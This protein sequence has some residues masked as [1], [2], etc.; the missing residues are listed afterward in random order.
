MTLT[1]PPETPKSDPNTGNIESANDNRPASQGE[2]L[3]PA[4][5]LDSG[6]RPWKVVIGCFCLTVPTFGLLSGISLF[7]TY[8]HKYQ[9][10][11]YTD[12]EISWIISIFGFL[13]CFF[14]AP[15]GILFD[16]Y[17][18]RW[19]LLVGSMVYV[20]A[21]IGLAFSSTYAKFMGCLTVAGI[22]AA[23]PTTIAFSIV[24]QWFSAREGLAT[25]CVSLGAAV[26]GIFF[27]L[28]L[29]NLFDK[30]SWT[31]VALI[32]SVIIAGFMA[33]G[34]VLV[35]TN[36]SRRPG[37][38]ALE[39]W[40]FGQVTQLLQSPKFWLISYAV[41]AYEV[42]LFIQ[43]GSIPAYAVSVDFG[44]NQFYLV[45]SYNIGAI[46]GR[47][48]PP[49]LSDRKIGPI[50][51]II[52]MN[53]FTLLAVLV[54]WLPFGAMN[55]GALLVVTM[56]MGIGTGSFVPLGGKLT[57]RSRHHS[58]TWLG[59]VYSMVSFAT[60]IGNPSTGAII[61][62]FKSN[63]LVAFLAAILVSGLVSATVLRWLCHERRWTLKSRI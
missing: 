56:L 1:T 27:S 33:L 14:A 63:G 17:G 19:L 39:A 44:G 48:V 22:S 23:S 31:V 3:R 18:A 34:N 2:Q 58:G 30:Y 11:S 41:F 61:E 25:G 54:I 37:G 52:L 24:S 49:W 26:G 4:I 16:R 13:D 8:W 51:T 40:D 28:V 46:I 6:W 55:I 45:M 15:F 21:F 9:L 62:R 35:E 50:N 38:T 53:V 32:L 43:W 59:C 29:Q 5:G 10:H 12:S 36:K 42:V 60:L 20:A 57:T 47:T 7:Q